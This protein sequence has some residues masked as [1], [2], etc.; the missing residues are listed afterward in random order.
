[1][2]FQLFVLAYFIY[3]TQVSAFLK[4]STKKADMISRAF[5]FG[6]N[7]CAERYHICII[8]LFRKPCSVLFQHNAHLIPFTLLAAIASPLPLPPITIPNRFLFLLR[9]RQPELRNPDNPQ[10]PLKKFRSH[11]TL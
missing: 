3:S 11:F 9:F 7:P 8:M 10:P 2:C 1:V 4:S 6:S 5:V